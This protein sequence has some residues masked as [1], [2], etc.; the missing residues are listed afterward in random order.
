[1]LVAPGAVHA[2]VPELLPQ[3]LPSSQE[4]PPPLSGE[5]GALVLHRPWSLGL[6]SL[7]LL[8]KEQMRQIYFISCM[9][10]P[11][12]PIFCWIFIIFHFKFVILY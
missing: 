7:S 9:F 1:M 8:G 5:H 2:P 6:S 3:D 12:L 4:F 10:M 11:L